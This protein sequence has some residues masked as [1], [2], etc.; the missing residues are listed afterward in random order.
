VIDLAQA[1]VDAGILSIVD[2]S[3]LSDRKTKKT[4]K[5]S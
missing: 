1:L 3:S 2:S 5:S 4:R